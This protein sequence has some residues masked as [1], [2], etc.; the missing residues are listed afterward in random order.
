[1]TIVDQIDRFTRLALIK[2]P[3]A[4]VFARQAKIA[5]GPQQVNNGARPG[6]QDPSERPSRA[7]ISETEGIKLLESPNE[8]LDVGATGFAGRSDQAMAT[9]GTF[10]RTENR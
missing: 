2:N 4:A 3:P 8:R 7:E 5:H 10:H 6:H 9:M 1:M